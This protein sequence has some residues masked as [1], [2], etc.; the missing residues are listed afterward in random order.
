MGEEQRPDRLG[1]SDR[2]ILA[3]SHTVLG[4]GTG[5]TIGG[6]WINVI[7]LPAFIEGRSVRPDL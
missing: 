1:Q 5:N 2:L 6:Y 4:K 7:F 3:H